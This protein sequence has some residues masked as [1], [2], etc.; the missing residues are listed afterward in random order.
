MILIGEKRKL[1]MREVFR[2]PLGSIPYS[3]ANADGSLRNTNKAFKKTVLSTAL[4]NTE[5]FFSVLDNLI[6]F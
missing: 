4:C 5:G 6:L 3:L 2:H 1:N